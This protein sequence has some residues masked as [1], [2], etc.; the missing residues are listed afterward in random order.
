MGTRADF[1]TG[2]GQTAQWLGSIA[3]GGYPVGTERFHC[4][5]EYQG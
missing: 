4:L 5:V 3:W 1:Y 2:R